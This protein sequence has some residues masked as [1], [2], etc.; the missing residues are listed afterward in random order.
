MTL[1]P[2]LRQG[3]GNVRGPIMKVKEG[4]SRMRCA[5]LEGLLDKIEE[6]IR[7]HAHST[8]S[9][10][11]SRKGDEEVLTVSPASSWGEVWEWTEKDIQLR[12]R[13][14]EVIREYQRR[15]VPHP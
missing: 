1:R 10:D 3:E 4:L 12:T 13:R 2:L 5:E 11:A 8:P 6:E 9:I 15:C 7:V 14:L